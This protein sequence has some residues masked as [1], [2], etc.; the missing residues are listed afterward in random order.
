MTSILCPAVAGLA[1][2]HRN[3]KTPYSS[4][5]KTERLISL[6]DAR[7]IFCRKPGIEMPINHLRAR[8]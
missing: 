5:P 6:S 2:T 8:R 3:P 1:A 4:L 7:S